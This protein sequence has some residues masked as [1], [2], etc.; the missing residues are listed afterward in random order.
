MALRSGLREEIDWALHELVRMSYELGDDIR[1]EGVNGLADCL[2]DKISS[3]FSHIPNTTPGKKR[4]AYINFQ[5]KEYD[6]VLEAMLILRNAALQEENAIYLALRVPRTKITVEK[7]LGLPCQEYPELMELR[8]YGL[9]VAESI[10]PFITI[11]GEDDALYIAMKQL[12]MSPERSSLILGLKALARM[13]VNDENNSLLQDISLDASVRVQQLLLLEDDEELVNAALDF[14]YQYTTYKSNVQTLVAKSGG[15]NKLVDS[16]V[17]LMGYGGKEQRVTINVLKRMIPLEKLNAEPPALSQEI[18]SGLLKLNEPERCIQWSH[19]VRAKSNSRVKTCYEEAPNEDIT[20]VSVWQ[21]YQ[22]RFYPYSNAPM[23]KPILQPAEMIKNV[24]VA[25]PAANAM[26]F[27]APE[28]KRFTIRG[29]RPREFA[30][31]L[32]GVQGFGCK[33]TLCGTVGKGTKGLW[34]HILEA[35]LGVKRNPPPTPPPPTANTNGTTPVENGHP[36]DSEEDK[37]QLDTPPTPARSTHSPIKPVPQICRWKN[38]NRDFSRDSLARFASHV[39]THIPTENLKIFS[40]PKQDPFSKFDVTYRKTGTDE[41]GEATGVPVTAG[42]VLRNL[43]RAEKRDRRGTD[44]RGD[45]VSMVEGRMVGGVIGVGVGSS[46]G[47]LGEVVMDL[48]GE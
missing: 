10:I 47:G 12:L 45:L 5:P 39:K 9:D 24:S 33:W 14:L 46:Q 4:P 44:V 36:P 48:L 25:Y 7:I 1:L 21:A 30:R 20:Q 23:C 3:L 38:C 29:V 28:G 27:D 2:I 32:D 31:G 13:A 19:T 17:R 11:A 15:M 40:A 34:E 8:Y 37:M 16:L 43:M 18:L 26:V 41:R 42:L 6:K 35:H 22:N